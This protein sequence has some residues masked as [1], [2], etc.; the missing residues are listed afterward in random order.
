MSD[1]RQLDWVVHA[2]KF[3]SLQHNE[4][5]GEQ[6]RDG[7]NDNFSWNCGAEGE[8]LWIFRGFVEGLG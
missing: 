7:S 1:T 6:G 5:N 3:P 4:A 8:T 2:A